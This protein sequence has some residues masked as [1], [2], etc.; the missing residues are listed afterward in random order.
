MPESTFDRF[1]P[2]IAAHLAVDDDKVVP[3]A[4][5]IDD[6]GADSLD[7]VE[8]ELAAEEEFGIEFPEGEGF[9]ADATVAAMIEKIDAKLAG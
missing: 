1:K 5:P 8:L 6:L 4:C 9:G 3:D 2:I 7:I